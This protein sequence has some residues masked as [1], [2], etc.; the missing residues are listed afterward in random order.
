MAWEEG[1]WHP[2]PGTGH[3]HVPTGGVPGAGSPPPLQDECL[4]FTQEWWQAYMFIFYIFFYM[5]VLK[6]Y[7]IY[8]KI[9]VALLYIYIAFYMEQYTY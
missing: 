4:A 5:C 7:F 3:P 8:L 9:F 6:I 2:G 1:P